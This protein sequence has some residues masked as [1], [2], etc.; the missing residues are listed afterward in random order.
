MYFSPA[1]N[2]YRSIFMRRN[3]KKKK[4]KKLVNGYGRVVVIPI[5]GKY[6][7]R[8]SETIATT[9]GRLDQNIGQ[10]LILKHY[11]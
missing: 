2:V 3:L 7:I 6:K 4:I 9:M 10:V 1:E 5:W 8:V 11:I